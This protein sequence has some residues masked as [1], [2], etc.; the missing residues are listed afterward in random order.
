MRW[1]ILWSLKKVSRISRLLSAFFAKNSDLSSSSQAIMKLRLN[2]MIL[3]RDKRMSRIV[4][5][6]RETP[7]FWKSSRVLISSVG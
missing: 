3:M 2:L 1:C 5:S 7:W 4:L 6:S